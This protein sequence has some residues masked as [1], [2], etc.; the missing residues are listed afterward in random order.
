MKQAA[1]GKSEGE[2]F[3]SA[4]HKFCEACGAETSPE[5]IQTGRAKV[6]KGVFLCA[7]CAAEFA[8]L[9]AA[10]RGTL[11]ELMG[12]LR[13]MKAGK[14]QSGDQTEHVEQKPGEDTVMGAGPV[15]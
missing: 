14:K 8:K 10:G 9:D 4:K 1:M 2:T 5:D 3:L 15:K 13:A 7:R 12:V 11:A 6:M